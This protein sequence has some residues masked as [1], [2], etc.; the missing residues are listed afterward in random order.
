M[1]RINFAA[2]VLHDIFVSP[3]SRLMKMHP[4]KISGCSMLVTSTFAALLSIIIII[5][6]CKKESA[7][8]DRKTGFSGDTCYINKAGNKSIIYDSS[9]RIRQFDQLRIEYYENEAK[10]YAVTGGTLQYDILFNDA[11]E[12]TMLKWMPGVLYS[13]SAFWKFTYENGRM[14]TRAE[15]NANNQTMYF[16]RYYWDEKGDMAQELVIETLAGS[17]G[18]VNFEYYQ[19][20]YETRKPRKGGLQEG[21]Y[22]LLT[23]NVPSSSVHLAKFYY[24]TNS[25]GTFKR[26]LDY[27]IS[28]GKVTNCYMIDNAN[29][30]TLLSAYEYSCF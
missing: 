14:T 15:L 20:K 10:V 6:S 24:E 28:E 12:I 1:V 4:I 18:F 29:N 13:D 30:K 3:I 22:N 17:S 27:D 7:P 23:I 26:V 19:D 5:S 8:E 9:G 25:W 16:T 11:D 2:L 21:I